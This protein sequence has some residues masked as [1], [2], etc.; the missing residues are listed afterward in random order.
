M[1]NARELFGSIV[2]SPGLGL[3]PD[4]WEWSPPVKWFQIPMVPA[5]SV[6]FSIVPPCPKFDVFGLGQ[7]LGR[8]KHVSSTG[9]YLVLLEVMRPSTSV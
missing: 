4:D 5:I 6:D 8:N 7:F 2:L 9:I 3:I 1:L